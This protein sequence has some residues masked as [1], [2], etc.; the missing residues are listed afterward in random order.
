MGRCGCLCDRKAC[1]TKYET[2]DE[3][4]HD[5]WSYELKLWV[6]AGIFWLDK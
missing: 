3:E 4:L 2:G 1:K 5:E 6:C